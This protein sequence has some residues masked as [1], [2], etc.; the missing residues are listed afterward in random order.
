MIRLQLHIRAHLGYNHYCSLC[1]FQHK[2]IEMVKKH[3]MSKKHV[4][5]SVKQKFVLARTLLPQINYFIKDYIYSYRGFGK[6]WRRNPYKDHHLSPATKFF[7]VLCSNN[8]TFS[9]TIG[10]KR[11]LEDHVGVNFRRGDGLKYANKWI[12]AQINFVERIMEKND[13][14]NPSLI[15]NL[16]TRIYDNLMV[17]KSCSV[18]TNICKNYDFSPKTKYILSYKHKV[19][20]NRHTRAHL[21]LKAFCPYCEF[22]SIDACLVCNHMKRSHSKIGFPLKPA[23]IPELMNLLKKVVN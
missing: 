18:C 15:V 2:N 13:K 8:R 4:L 7:C 19:S 6:V 16:T 17:C 23:A 14:K 10:F 21:Q 3:L 1:N 12:N 9:T 20:I 5:V 11:H 22:E